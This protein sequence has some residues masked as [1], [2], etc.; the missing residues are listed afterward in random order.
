MR[1]FRTC[2]VVFSRPRRVSG[3]ST[4]FKAAFGMFSGS[5]GLLEQFSVGARVRLKH[6]W[7]W[8]AGQITNLNLANRVHVSWDN[9][10][11]EI[12]TADQLSP[13]PG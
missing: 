3:E 1:R 5:S 8:P 2:M 12:T 6:I 4:M 13:E 10:L 11:Q 9:G 7:D